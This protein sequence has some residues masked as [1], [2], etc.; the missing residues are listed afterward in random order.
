MN[1][2]RNQWEFP[3]R[4]R[5][6]CWL[7]NV[8]PVASVMG[9][10]PSRSSDPQKIKRWKFSDHC[11][12][13]AAANTVL[14]EPPNICWIL[15]ICHCELIAQA[16]TQCLRLWVTVCKTVCPILS[17]WCLSVCLF[18]SVCLSVC[19]SGTFVYC[20]QT[21]RWIKMPV[22]MEIG[23]GLGHIVLDPSSAQLPLK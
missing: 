8:F 15:L 19:L 18:L 10:R 4:E 21:V 7:P 5:A 17:D 20:G 13:R 14:D 23:L 12:L 3:I 9:P 1:L 2:F 6:H 22:G 11:R 16:I